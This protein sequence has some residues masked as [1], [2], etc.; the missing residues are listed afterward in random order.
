MR[1]C[2]TVLS[3]IAFLAMPFV[4]FGTSLVTF[5]VLFLFLFTLWVVG[6]GLE[7]AGEKLERWA[8]GDNDEE[9]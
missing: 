1:G 8:E 9:E 5:I 3:F 4:L 7:L 6:K 2:I